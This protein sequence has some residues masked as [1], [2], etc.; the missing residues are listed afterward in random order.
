LQNLQL[1]LA[2]R[3]STNFNQLLACQSLWEEKA[4]AHLLLLRPYLASIYN[5]SVKPYIHR[6]TALVP[7]TTGDAI[8][9]GD[10]YVLTLILF[11]F[12]FNL[13]VMPQANLPDCFIWSDIFA[14]SRS[15]NNSSFLENACWWCDTFVSQ[16]ELVLGC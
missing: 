11:L 8:V 13:N 7:C 9:G 15:S 12:D 6:Q 5:S 4:S 2:Q 3:R 1:A 10:I 14:L 16:S